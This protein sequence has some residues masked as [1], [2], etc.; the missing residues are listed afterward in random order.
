MFLIFEG[1][2][3]RPEAPERLPRGARGCTLA[4]FGSLGSPR[5]FPGTTLDLLGGSS[6]TSFRPFG[7]PK[8]AAKL[9]I[10]AVENKI[11]K[12]LTI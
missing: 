12:F 2:G 8:G 3:E 9:K 7:V 1:P 5:G 10:R 6:G 4:R 11:Y